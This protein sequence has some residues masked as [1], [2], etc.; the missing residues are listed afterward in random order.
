[1]L[2]RGEQG[3]AQS[4]VEEAGPFTRGGD[5][6]E[7]FVEPRER[8]WGRRRQYS[9]A[10]FACRKT[11]A[12]ASVAIRRTASGLKTPIHISKSGVCSIEDVFLGREEPEQVAAANLVFAIGQQI[13]T[14]ALA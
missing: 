9:P 5:F 10:G 1:M 13:E 7:Q 14:G 4:G 12:F 3:V 6:G 8:R 11:C 2:P